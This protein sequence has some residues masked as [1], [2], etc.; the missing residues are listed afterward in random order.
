MQQKEINFHKMVFNVVFM[1]NKEEF[2]SNVKW[3]Q[4]LKSVHLIRNT[5]E[6]LLSLISVSIKTKVLG[7]FF[8]DKSM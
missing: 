1:A 8:Q 5:L 6:V 7:L 2:L 4:T 3:E